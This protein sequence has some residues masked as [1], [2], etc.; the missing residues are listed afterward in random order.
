MGSDW[1]QR[2]TKTF[3]KTWDTGRVAA[4]TADLFTRQP[5]CAGRAAPADIVGNAR[6]EVGENVTVQKEGERY[7]VRREL[8]I[9]ARFASLPAGLL[10]AVE[11]STGIACGTVEAVHALA[12]VVE[13]SLC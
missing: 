5:T 11:A 7:I 4:G 6:F 2:A 10:E 1:V 8:M 12:G 13:I 9:V 3:L